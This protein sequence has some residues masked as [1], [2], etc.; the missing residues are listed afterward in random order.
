LS[1]SC[2]VFRAVFPVAGFSF[3]NDSVVLF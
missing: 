2:A 3:E 1:V